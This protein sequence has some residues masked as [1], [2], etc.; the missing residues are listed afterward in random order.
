M[1]AETV[2]LQQEEGRQSVR[3]QRLAVVGVLVSA[4]IFSGD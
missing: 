4:L 3:V 1:G 2:P